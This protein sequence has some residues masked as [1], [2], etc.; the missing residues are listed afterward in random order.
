MSVTPYLWPLALSAALGASLAV[1]AWR[2]PD[3]PGA[4]PFAVLVACS[5]VATAL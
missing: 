5:A 1:Y 2:R 3:A 4:R